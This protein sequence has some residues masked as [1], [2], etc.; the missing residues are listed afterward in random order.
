MTFDRGRRKGVLAAGRM[1]RN[2]ANEEGEGG[3]HK[4]FIM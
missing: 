1:A 2:Q 3:E 4:L